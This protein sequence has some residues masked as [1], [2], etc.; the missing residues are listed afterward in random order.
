MQS[1]KDLNIFLVDDDPMFLKILEQDIRHFFADVKIK[2][3]LTAEDCL[4]GIDEHPDAVILDY[5]LPG[6]NGFSAFLKI[7]EKDPDMPVVILSG[8]GNVKVMQQLFS[9]GVYDYVIKGSDYIQELRFSI[10]EIIRRKNKKSVL[11]ILDSDMGA[12]LII[13]IIMFI[14]IALTLAFLNL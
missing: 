9:A 10:S 5:F 11:F 6:M 4:K 1:S 14:L 8:I 13:G 2:T 12:V 7:K 3:F